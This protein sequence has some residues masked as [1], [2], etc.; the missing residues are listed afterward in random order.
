MWLP[1]DE[2]HILLAYYENIFDLGDRDAE[3]FLTQSKWFYSSDWTEVLKFPQWIPIVSSYWVGKRAKHIKDHD[4][5]VASPS[6]GD[7]L[8]EKGQRI[9]DETVQFIK[10]L[11]IANTHLKDRKLI[12]ITPQGSEPRIAGVLLTLDGYDLARR[13]SHWFERT[14]LWFR[15]YK[16]HWIGLV[17]GFIGGVLGALVV[18]WLSD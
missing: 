12:E 15:E 5:R 11:E 3:K 14:G 10:R 2:R 9:L 13:Y 16:D 7:I 6:K 4:N 1:R 8:S 17:V 18:Q